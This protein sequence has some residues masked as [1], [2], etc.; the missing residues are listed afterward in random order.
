[1]IIIYRDNR[2]PKLQQLAVNSLLAK[3]RL[4]IARRAMQFLI[5]SIVLLNWMLA[6]RGDLARRRR[7]LKRYR[8]ING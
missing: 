5:R 7:G 1:M 3:I 4:A 6:R 2:N 8:S